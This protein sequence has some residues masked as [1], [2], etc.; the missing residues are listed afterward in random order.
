MTSSVDKKLARSKSAFLH[1]F[2][3]VNLPIIIGYKSNYR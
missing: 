3:L 1:S 2:Q